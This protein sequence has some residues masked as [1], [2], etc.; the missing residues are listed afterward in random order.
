MPESTQRKTEDLHEKE[1]GLALLEEAIRSTGN[2]QELAERLGIS[3]PAISR[4]RE[5][6]RVPEGRQEDMRRLLGLVNDLLPP[7]EL[8]E[9]CQSSIRRTR[10]WAISAWSLFYVHDKKD[11]R[12]EPLDLSLWRYWEHIRPHAESG[13]S[14]TFGH[15]FT[16][17][18]PEPKIATFGFLSGDCCEVIEQHDRTSFS[19]RHAFRTREDF[20]SLSG[21]YCVSA[22]SGLTLRT[23]VP[24]A[25]VGF[26]PNIPASTAMMVVSL[27]RSCYQYL[28]MYSSNLDYE[29]IDHL[30]AALAQ[31]GSTGRADE[32][33]APNGERLYSQL[34]TRPPADEIDRMKHL[35]RKSDI[36]ERYSLPA[37]YFGTSK[38]DCIY[39]RAENIDPLLTLLAIWRRRSSSLW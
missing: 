25:F 18:S 4:W 19:L 30:L 36:S 37:D 6:G 16:T 5:K 21:G 27:P 23:D 29:L 22:P 39:F 3:S 15:S 35:M 17:L 31:D 38:R 10:L 8:W 32:I 2:Q 26:T 12:D 33:L 20:Q 9:S 1:V 13:R 28:Q 34:W 11:D 7:T 14:V 24:M